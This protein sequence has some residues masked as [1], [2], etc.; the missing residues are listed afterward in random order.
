MK[1]CH[2]YPSYVG[3][4]VIE[5]RDGQ[6]PRDTKPAELILKVDKE[7]HKSLLESLTQ[8]A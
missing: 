7:K 1:G 2:V 5:W 8:D 4:L 6:H 3:M